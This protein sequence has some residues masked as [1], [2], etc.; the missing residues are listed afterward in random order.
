ML[1]EASLLRKIYPENQN[2]Y[3]LYTFENKDG[4]PVA[5]LPSPTV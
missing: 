5:L 4:T 1:E 2:T 3:G